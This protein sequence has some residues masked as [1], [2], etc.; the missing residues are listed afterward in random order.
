MD[1]ESRLLTALSIEPAEQRVLWDLMEGHSLSAEHFVPSST[2][3][4]H[5]VVHYGRNTLPAF[6]FFQKRFYRV[7]D[8]EIAGFNA[9][10]LSWL[11]GPGYFVTH[12]V[13]DGPADFVI[14]YT[15]LPKQKPA[16]CPPIQPNTRGVS[17]WVYG[18]MKDYVRSVSE[19]VCIGRAYRGE[20]PLD[21][22]FVLCRADVS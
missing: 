2:E 21:A 17:R 7:P 16:T 6:K 20:K 18:G 13:T 5:P 8:D 22:W 19:H 4:L 14:D 10:T 9:Q 1:P 12:P 11:T 15:A 3:P